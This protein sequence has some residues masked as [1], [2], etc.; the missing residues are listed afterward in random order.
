MAWIVPYIP[1]IIS[2]ISAI[3]GASS[4]SQAADFNSRLAEQNAEA[5]RQQAAR[6]AEKQ[7]IEDRKKIGA[8]NAARAAS[9]LTVEGSALDA[10]NEG[11]V[12]MASNQQ[13]IL[14][15]GEVSAR[16]NLV[17]AQA[18]SAQSGS[19]LTG[20]FL[21]AGSSFLKQTPQIGRSLNL[22]GSGG[23][24]GSGGL[25]AGAAGGLDA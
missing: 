22:Q 18:S 6:Q 9:G 7:A 4:E 10:L 20:G 15:Q 2:G 3:A 17:R 16:D 23:S 1:A 24:I 8:M 12:T 19:A 21:S 11:F 5:A 25:S 14:F 13:D